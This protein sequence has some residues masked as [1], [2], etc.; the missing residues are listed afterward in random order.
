MLYKHH[1]RSTSTGVYLAWG[2][3]SRETARRVI[4]SLQ[5]LGSVSRISL[6][7]INRGAKIEKVTDTLIIIQDIDEWLWQDAQTLE[8]M[9]KYQLIN[10]VYASV[11]T[12]TDG[13]NGIVL[14]ITIVPLS[15][16]WSVLQGLIA[17]ATCVC[18]FLWINY[19]YVSGL[20]VGS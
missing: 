13:L 4:T 12:D 17:V 3:S 2:Y 18:F 14:S 6:H 10:H 19:V 9:C 7:L 1:A 15:K 16:L 5:S 11:S 8:H 20:L